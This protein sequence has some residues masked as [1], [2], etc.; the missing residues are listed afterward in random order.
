M[1]EPEKPAKPL[2][3]QHQRFVVE[4]MQDFNAE[5][6][7]ARAGY[8]AANRA[9][10]MRLMHDSRIL[11]EIRKR[12]LEVQVRLEMNGDD[13]RRG[14]ARI[15][16]DPRTRKQ[17]GPSYMARITALRELAKLFGMYTHKIQVTGSLTLVDLL[18]AADRKAE[19]L[20]APEARH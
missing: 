18:L 5:K 9:G 15:A 11:D 3:A 6:A 20:P 10:P 4:Y 17:G 2:S 8:A 12:C 14:F 1:G 13:V 7:Y 19:A 16:T